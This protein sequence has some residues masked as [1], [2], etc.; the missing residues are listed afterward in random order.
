MSKSD[1][2]SFWTTGIWVLL[3]YLALPIMIC[4]G[5][6]L[7]GGPSNRA[8]INYRLVSSIAPFQ[9]AFARLTGDAEFLEQR[10]H[11]R[12]PDLYGVNVVQLSDL[13]VAAEVPVVNLKDLEAVEGPGRVNLRD[14]PEPVEDSVVFLITKPEPDRSKMLAIMQSPRPLPRP[15]T[16]E[17]TLR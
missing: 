8:K 15:V 14:L 1:H 17:I 3:R 10:V 16:A 9:E 2:S 13:P 11:V 12:D 7:L 5:I 6:Y 4:A